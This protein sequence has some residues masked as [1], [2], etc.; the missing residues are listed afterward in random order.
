MKEQSGA[1]SFYR[2]RLKV[3]IEGFGIG[4]LV[5]MAHSAGITMKNLRIISDTEAEGWI[6][7]SDLTELRSLA[8]SRY[9]I[10]VLE[11]QGAEHRVRQAVRRPATLA[12]VLIAS[13]I[14]AAQ[15]LFVA[16]VKIDGY[17]AI[18]EDSLRLC[19]EEAGICVGAFRP[20]I[21]WE[22]ARA[23]L[24]ETFPQLTWMQ[25]V[26]DGRMVILNVA[27]SGSRILSS[28]AEPDSDI[29]VPSG[30]QEKIYASIVADRSGYIEEISTLWGAAMV[31]AGD[32]V[33]D[34]DV[35]ISGVVAM[36]PTTFQEDWPTEY[37]V[38][39]KGEITALVP[40]RLTFNQERYIADTAEP[41][42]RTLADRREKTREEAEAV[43]N[44]QIRLWIKEN[45]PENAEIVNESL[46]F[47]TKNNIIEIGMTLEVRQQIGIEKEIIVGSENSDN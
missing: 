29:F 12:G 13:A 26:Y 6:A 2:Q 19:L 46:N 15:S 34:G 9:R 7:A 24:R 30:E 41:G 20:S 32:Y 31:E 23:A 22:G 17:R 37:Y 10:I 38:R 45:L 16:S 25:L 1:W 5:N 33:Q 28:E 8:R 18:P 42:E 35:L 21:D 27:E 47:S 4:R 3:K 43:L 36:E 14:V 11:R 44:Q 39:A 40:Y